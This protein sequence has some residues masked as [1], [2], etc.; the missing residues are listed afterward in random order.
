MCVG[1][2][3]EE[4]GIG[5]VWVS[6]VGGGVSLSSHCHEWRGKMGGTV[7]RYLSLAKCVLQVMKQRLKIV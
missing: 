5:G 4:E 3:G 2:G 1:G 7:I 6:G